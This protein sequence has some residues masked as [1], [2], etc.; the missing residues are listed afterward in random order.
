MTRRSGLLAAAAAALSGCSGAQVLDRLVPRSGYRDE[1]G[2]AYGAEPRQRL[3][4]FRP[5]AGMPA[6]A[7]RR[8]P[9]IVVFFYGGSWTHGERAEY[10]FVGEALATQGA[11]VVIPDYRLSPGV[12]YPVFL[13]DCAAAVRWVFDHAAALGGDPS[14]IVLM[15]HSAGG[16]NAAMLA[17]DPRWLGAQG[18]APGQLAAWIGMAGAYDFLPIGDPETQVAFGWPDTP[19]DSQPLVHASALAPRTLLLV[20]EEDRLV[21]PQRNTRALAQTLH[22]LHVDVTLRQYPRI[23]HVMLVGSLGTPLRWLA[24]V[25][26]DVL[27]FLGL[28]A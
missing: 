26:A 17:L 8:S 10:R 12:R 9:P 27:S 2:V 23:G 20:S 28:P 19:A 7:G 4:I 6:P 5:P 22:A 14:H 15:G 24:P 16:Y 11:I 1:R 3:D 21:D 25:R 13:Q 18:L